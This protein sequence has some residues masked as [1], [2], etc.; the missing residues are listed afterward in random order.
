MCWITAVERKSGR[1]L[2][3]GRSGWRGRVG[4]EKVKKNIK[5]MPFRPNMLQDFSFLD[6]LPGWVEA[7]R[8]PSA[9]RL[10]SHPFLWLSFSALSPCYRFN[11]LWPRHGSCNNSKCNSIRKECDTVVRLRA[12]ERRSVLGEVVQGEARVLPLHA[13]GDSVDKDFQVTWHTGRCKFRL[14]IVNSARTLSLSYSAQYFY[15]KLEPESAP[16]VW[17]SEHQSSSNLI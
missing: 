9:F 4:R 12:G 10:I 6:R 13:E 3:R 8:R 2:A 5:Q 14:L 15:E 1:S 17:S 7:Q 11:R 16:A